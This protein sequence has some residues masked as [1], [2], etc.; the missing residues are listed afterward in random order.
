MTSFRV[1]TFPHKL[2]NPL[3]RL[4]VYDG[5]IMNAERWEVSQSYFRHRQNVLFQAASQSG[6]V[7]GLGVKVISAPTWSRSRTRSQDAQNLERRWLEIQPG[8]AIDALGNPIVV[9]GGDERDRTFR[10]ATLPPTAGSLTVYIVARYVEPSGYIANGKY[11]TLPE[12]CRFEE[13]TE[14]PDTLDVELCRFQLTS[15]AVQLSMPR[16]LFSP[17]PRELDFRYRQI[18]RPKLIANVRM[19]VIGQHPQKVHENF[20]YLHR[21][22]SGHA[23]G[24]H[25]DIVSSTL[26]FQESLSVHSFDALYVTAKELQQMLTRHSRWVEEFVGHGGTLIFETTSKATPNFLPQVQQLFNCLKP[27]QDL[28]APHPL[29]TDPFL[30][31]QS[32]V[33]EGQVIELSIAE[34]LVWIGGELSSAWGIHRALPRADIRTAQEVGANLM[35]YIWHRKHMTGLFRW[36]ARQ[37]SEGDGAGGG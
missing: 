19:G 5:L 25:L 24:V 2:P 31:T 34:G 16:D 4:N 36:Q 23:S 37:S 12:Q 32:P 11:D 21:S 28:G 22:M 29:K 35:R 18:V 26:Q 13:R 6:I 33:I 8:I 9:G 7:C 10:I 27:W 14:P 15:G 30:F 1:D 3:E 20:D 17:T